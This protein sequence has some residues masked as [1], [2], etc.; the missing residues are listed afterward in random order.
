MDL[1]YQKFLVHL[2]RRRYRSHL[3][4]MLHL[5]FLDV[6]TLNY[7]S[8]MDLYCLILLVRL[9]HHLHHNRLLP[10]L[11]LLGLVQHLLLHV[12]DRKGLVD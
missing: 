10:K 2:V 3:L 9:V 12:L 7:K 6:L 4:T 8:Q 11:H 5:L 1:Y